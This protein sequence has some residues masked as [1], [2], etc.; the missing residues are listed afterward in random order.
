MHGIMKLECIG[1]FGTFKYKK[2]GNEK[3]SINFTFHSMECIHQV[4][5]QNAEP[6]VHVPSFLV[7]YSIFSYN[8]A[9]KTSAQL[10]LCT[11]I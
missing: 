3:Y 9:R 2:Y 11:K 4:L 6:I 10:L 8:D 5:T 1:V 7:Y